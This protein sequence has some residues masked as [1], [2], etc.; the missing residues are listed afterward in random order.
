MPESPES[1]HP[2]ELELESARFELRSLL[3]R[4]ESPHPSMPMNEAKSQLNAFGEELHNNL[5]FELHYTGAAEL[6]QPEGRVPCEVLHQPV[7]LRGMMGKKVFIE[8]LDGGELTGGLWIPVQDAKMGLNISVAEGLLDSNGD[9]VEGV[10]IVSRELTPEDYE[11]RLQL[12]L[13]LLT[14]ADAAPTTL[15]EART[16]LEELARTIRSKPDSVMRF[17]GEA[18]SVADGAVSDFQSAE[19]GL[20]HAGPYDTRIT[21]V[22][23]GQEEPFAV[24][25]T[26]M[27]N[28]H[29]HEI[30][31]VAE[32]VDPEAA[33][34][35]AVKIGLFA[36][37]AAT[38]AD[39][40]SDYY[41]TLIDPLSWKTREG[42]E[43]FLEKLF[44]EDYDAP[45]RMKADLQLADI[46][47]LV[48]YF[49]DQT[50]QNRAASVE[51]YYLTYD[52]C[53]MAHSKAV[54]QQLRSAGTQYELATHTALFDEFLKRTDATMRITFGLVDVAD[55]REH[56]SPLVSKFYETM[57]D[58][59]AKLGHV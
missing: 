41:H 46:D 10:R 15:Q 13:K 31:A 19:I 26:Q 9:L 45:E 55:P 52:E 18:T 23:G 30:E 38:E 43:A 57:W 14:T 20:L 56:K 7:R 36:N 49:A 54:W 22:G 21:V 39:E 12:L 50:Y 5:Q 27:M 2:V 25:I 11:T 3:D 59:L 53:L 1:R 48:R 34:L 33:F 8:A 44:M 58:R 16:E 29:V 32:V 35:D 40:L 6:A 28:F 42:K 17:N 37:G 47:V 4:F 51:T 24:D